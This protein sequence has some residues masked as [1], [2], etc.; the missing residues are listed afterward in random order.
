MKRNFY[1]LLIVFFSFFAQDAAAQIISTIAGNGTDGYCCDDSLAINAELSKP[2]DVAIDGFGNIIIAD[3]LN[4]RIR[5]IDNAGIITT[6]AGT[7]VAG[8]NGDNMA[9]TA[10]MINYPSALIA[11]ATGNIFFCDDHNYRIRMIDVHGIISTIAGTGLSGYSGD[12]GLATDAMITSSLGIAID[13]FGQIYF[14]DSRNYRIRK[15]SAATGGIITTIAGN[16]TPGYTGDDGAATNAELNAPTGLTLD[17]I[18][19][20]YFGEHYNNCIRKV[21]NDGIIKT[22]AG[23]GLPGYSG[24]NGPATLA[25]LS[26]PQGIKID[27]GGDIYFADAYNNRI[28]KIDISGDITTIAGSGIGGYTGDGGNA[29]LAD[30]STPTGIALDFAGNFYIADLIN[31]RIRY[32][33]NT[34]NINFAN[35][36]S[37]RMEIYP[38]P[39]EGMINVFVPTATTEKVNYLITN[40][41]GTKIQEGIAAS[42]EKLTI[43]IV[44]P[45]GVYIIQVS[46]TSQKIIKKIVISR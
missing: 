9:A 30:L 4:N 6:I 27:G 33:K 26:W 39:S 2:F 11:D 1:L 32:Y 45:S 46:T 24:D 40:A 8:Y 18:G 10:A 15:I 12:N 3:A 25:K 13:K 31:N 17:N 5:K 7:G 14:S 28:R 34:T 29:I 42:N 22:I 43:N 23:T 21:G 19:N 36:S 37:S 41:I 44:A 16:G 35:K 38:N 20:I